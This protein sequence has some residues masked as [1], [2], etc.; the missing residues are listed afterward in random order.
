M[1][2]LGLGGVLALWAI[3]NTVLAI[4]FR[5]GRAE[6][7]RRRIYQ[8]SLWPAARRSLPYGLFPISG[9]LLVTSLTMIAQVA[10]LRGTLISAG[11]LLVMLALGV[12]MVVFMVSK[13]SWLAPPGPVREF[14]APDPPGTDPRARPS[15]ASVLPGSAARTA[16]T[17]SGRVRPPTTPTT[18]TATSLP[19]GPHIAV[20]RGALR[21]Q[22]PN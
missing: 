21:V 2:L 16:G 20:S 8:Q 3:A 12:T 14:P 10:G 4:R 19:M 18:P 6:H 5:Q 17:G 9:I 7:L 13:P 15:N 22:M 1:A 11:Y